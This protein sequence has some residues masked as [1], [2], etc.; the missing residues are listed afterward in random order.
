MLRIQKEESIAICHYSRIDY[1]T[2]DLFAGS[3]FDLE[4][5]TKYECKF[6][7][8][9]PDGVIGE[10]EKRALVQ[11][12]PEPMPF[13]KGSVLHVYPREYKGA[14]MEP[15]FNNL[16]HAYYTGYCTADWWN[17][18]PPRV[19]PGDTILMHAGVYQEDWN[20]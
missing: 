20:F 12:R 19:Q 4:P 1:I 9:D 3:I 13:E 10:A 14:K 5:D 16:M 15:F 17:F 8:S 6:E 7:M 18:S 2:P 11:T